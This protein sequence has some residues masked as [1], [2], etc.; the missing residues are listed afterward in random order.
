MKSSRITTFV[1]CLSFIT[2]AVFSQVTSIPEQAKENFT[3]QY[4]GASNVKWSNDIVN[5][6]V[7]FDLDGEHMNA[8]YSNKGIWKS[9]LKD[10]SFEKLPEAVGIE[11]FKTKYSDRVVIVDVKV[12]YL[13]GDVVQYRLK[14]KQNDIQKKFLYFNEKGRLLRSAVTL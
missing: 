6:N 2:S 8:E 13:P 5:V 14:A 7:E 3:N 1:I 10:W 4:P 11:F 9:T 12:L